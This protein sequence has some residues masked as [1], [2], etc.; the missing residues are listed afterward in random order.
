MVLIPLLP[1]NV[2]WLNHAEFTLLIRSTQ[3][4]VVPQ[5]GVALSM[6]VTLY[7]D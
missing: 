4:Y 6:S 2:L 7:D 1:N 3:H 5:K